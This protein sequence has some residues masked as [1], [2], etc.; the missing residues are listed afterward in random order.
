M[1]SLA[2]TVPHLPWIDRRGRPCLLRGAVFL[3]LVAP[4]AWLLWR[5]AQGQLGPEPDKVMIQQT[6]L[7]TLRL[8]LVSL[9][10]SPCATMFA[11]PR[12]FQVRRM[13]GIAAFAYG[14]GH[15]FHFVAYHNFALLKSITEIALR[16]YLTI[17]LVALVGL[18]AL[19]L[20]STDAWMKRLGPVWKRLHRLAY[21]IGMLALLHFFI[22]SKADVSEPTIVAGLFVWLMA[23][24]GLPRQW[25]RHWVAPFALVPVAVL[26][27]AL[28]EYAWFA[29]TTAIPAGMVLLANLDLDF[30]PRP[31]V[32][33][34]IGAL[35]LAALTAVNRYK[36]R[37]AEGV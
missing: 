28:I 13:V 8:L 17:G 9:A 15:L 1:P 35:G 2:A 10:I 31:A 23:W 20:T 30:G 14:A 34:G 27:G 19:A 6:G 11:L 3:A 26:G 12:L 37:L 22:Q 24:R 5:L 33:A 36:L 29:T 7:W 25:Q 4:A 18:G 32:W 21:P 16:F